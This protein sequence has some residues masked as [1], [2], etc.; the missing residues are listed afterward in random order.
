MD[1]PDQPIN[2][3]ITGALFPFV[4]RASLLEALYALSVMGHGQQEELDRAW[5]M[6]A[7]KRDEEGK[8]ILDWNPPR[9]YFKPGKRGRPNKWITLYAYLALGHK[10]RPTKLV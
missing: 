6:L 7:A 9:A 8:Y 2:G 3:E 10:D 1:Q 4:W 5:D